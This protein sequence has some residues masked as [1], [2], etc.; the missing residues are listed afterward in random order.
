MRFPVVL[1]INSS[2]GIKSNPLD[3]CGKVKKPR[4]VENEFTNSAH[5]P[6]GLWSKELQKR[7]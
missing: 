2:I 4:G 7:F 1:V 6:P 3:G 5:N